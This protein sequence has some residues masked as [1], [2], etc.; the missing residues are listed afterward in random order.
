MAPKKK[1]K[2]PPLQPDLIDPGTDMILQSHART[3][4][5]L[6]TSLEAHARM[7]DKMDE[8]SDDPNIEINI[9]GDAEVLRI[10]G[11]QGDDGPEGRP[12]RDGKDADEQEI[13]KRVLDLLPK[14]KD[15][16]TPQKGKDYYTDADR[17][18]LI[19]ELVPFFPK[20]KMGPRGLP[21][22]DAEVD[23]ERVAALV[24]KAMPN[25]RN[26]KDGSPDTA[27]EIIKKI[28]G[29]FD[30]SHLKGLPIRH[31]S[32]KTVSLSELDDVDLSQATKNTNGKYIIEPAGSSGIV[33][34]NGKTGS[35]ITLLPSDIGSPSGSG[36]SMGSNT[37][38]QDLS[39]YAT[40]TGVETLTNKRNTKRTLALSA[41]SATP[42]INTDSYDVVHITGQTTAITSLTMTGTP[43]DGDTLRISVTGTTSISLALGSLFENSGTI[44]IPPTTSGTTRLDIGF[45]WNTETSKWRCQGFS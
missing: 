10:I 11:P 13:I 3:H 24:Q 21:G 34:V 43:V 7:L 9:N 26:G 28:K 41:N 19:R 18:D 22:K 12:G 2:T 4:K 15:G 20:G 8:P 30:Y 45:F 35:S 14:P 17:A 1:E 33:S 42:S 36:T 5:V 16:K 23:Y 27:E 6:E 29:K 44:T 37:G 32:S 31:P 25:I 39:G 40:K 38:D